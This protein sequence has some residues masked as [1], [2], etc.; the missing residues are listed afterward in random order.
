GEDG[1]P[2]YS[3]FDDKGVPTHNALGEEVNK[4]SRTALHII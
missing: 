3:Q 2:L 1:K 4:A